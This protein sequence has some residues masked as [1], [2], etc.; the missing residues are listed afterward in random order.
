MSKTLTYT[1]AKGIARSQCLAFTHIDRRQRTEFCISNLELD[2]NLPISEDPL[3]NGCQ[4][5]LEKKIIVHY[6]PCLY[7]RMQT[8]EGLKGRQF[9]I[10]EACARCESLPWHIVE[11]Y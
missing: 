4:D 2:L 9:P 7:G 8:K 1:K 11:K 5:L 3:M 10:N 6:M